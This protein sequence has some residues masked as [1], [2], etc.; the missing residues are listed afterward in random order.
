MS[1][2]ASQIS[3]EVP[4]EMVEQFEVLFKQCWPHDFINYPEIP[5]G[6]L[7]L[8]TALSRDRMLGSVSEAIMASTRSGPQI[9]ILLVKIGLRNLGSFESQDTQLAWVMRMAARW[10]ALAKDMSDQASLL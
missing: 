7:A 2:L 5:Q 9:E 6:P 10:R 4:E 3:A 8:M 1:Q